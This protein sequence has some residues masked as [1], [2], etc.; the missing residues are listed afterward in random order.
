MSLAALCASHA[1]LIAYG[2]NDVAEEGDV[3]AAYKRLGDFARAFKPD[4]AIQFSPDHFNG[5]FYD[6][7]PSFCIGTAAASLGDWKTGLGSFNVPEDIALDVAQAARDADIDVA[8][9]YRMKVDHGFTQIW[10]MMYGR[11]DVIPVVPVF[12][13]CAAPPLPPIR[14]VRA[15]GEAIGRFAA[16]SGKRV[17]FVASG[18]LSHDPPIPNLKSAP[19]DRREALIDGR[20]PTE[21]FRMRREKRVLD[22]AADAGAGKGESLPPDP[23]WD[24]EFL[25]MLEAGRLRDMDRWGDDAITAKA[26]CGGHEVRCW[27]AAFAALAAAGRYSSSVEYY[28]PITRWL[29]GMGMIRA[30][31]D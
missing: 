21:E 29:T 22:A 2:L 10:E 8:L 19:A 15:L 16:R 18:G 31:Q 30:H 28:Q 1:P 7:M 24:R 13:N 11:F 4:Y 3:R 6:L 17:L 5:F 14:R 12:I 27:I 9:S 23:K 25:Q 20:N 26:G